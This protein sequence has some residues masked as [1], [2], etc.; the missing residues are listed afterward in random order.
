MAPN[1][2]IEANNLSNE[3]V[4]EK[5]LSDPRRGILLFHKFYI[6]RIA[7]LTREFC[8]PTA[9]YANKIYIL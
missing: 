2:A 5:V 1:G 8:H 7:E 9:G 4:G 3:I 6:P